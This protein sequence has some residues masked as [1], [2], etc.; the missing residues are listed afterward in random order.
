[1]T[2]ITLLKQCNEYACS[3]ASVVFEAN[4]NGKNVTQ[5]ELIERFIQDFPSWDQRPGMLGPSGILRILTLLEME[6]AD[7]VATKNIQEARRFLIERDPYAGFVWIRRVPDGA[8]GSKPNDHCMVFRR[9]R[10]DGG[11]EVMDPAKPES[12][13]FSPEQFLLID[14]TILLC[15]EHTQNKEYR[16]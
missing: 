7:F 11:I 10:E 9:F 6:A 15:T 2:N 16:S 8:G 5:E 4:R 1:V 13:G 14:G 12:I 3:L